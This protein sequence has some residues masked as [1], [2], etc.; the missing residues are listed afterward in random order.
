[1]AIALNVDQLRPLYANEPEA[2]GD[3]FRETVGVTA[4][5]I[6]RLERDTA[7]VATIH[8]AHELKG[9]CRTVGAEE[10]AFLGAEIESLAQEGRWDE[11]ED[12]LFILRRA[13]ERLAEAV[14][15]ID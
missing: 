11:I 9:V 6:E 3:L 4:Q 12:R 1:M 7:T 8:A 14:A 10:L 15:A 5:L 13:H 2:L